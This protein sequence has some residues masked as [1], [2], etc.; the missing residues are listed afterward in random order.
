MYSA[1]MY[2]VVNFMVL[3]NPSNT[4]TARMTETMI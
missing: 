2:A 3:V 1:Y 4:V